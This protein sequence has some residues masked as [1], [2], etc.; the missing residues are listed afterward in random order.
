MTS[1]KPPI[2]FSFIAL[3][4]VGSHFTQRLGWGTKGVIAAVAA[5]L[6]L[7]FIGSIAARQVREYLADLSEQAAP[8]IE[9]PPPRVPI[10]RV[11]LLLLV[12]MPIINLLASPL[13]VPRGWAVCVVFNILLACLSP[14]ILIFRS[15]RPDRRKARLVLFY[16]HLS[17]AGAVL[18]LLPLIFLFE[19]APVPVANLLV[20]L[21]L[22]ALVAWNALF[23][24]FMIRVSWHFRYLKAVFA[25]RRYARKDQEA[26]LPLILATGETEAQ[27]KQE[28]DQPQISYPDLPPS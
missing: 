26:E 8:F 3:V 10:D 11:A 28:Y 15:A 17:R 1:I 27:P 9:P 19:G 6:L 24:W 5:S 4:L 18:G 20:F 23:F 25:S 12:A 16:I 22:P 7:T 13:I 14:A 2:L 21:I